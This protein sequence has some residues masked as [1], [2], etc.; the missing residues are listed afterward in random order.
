MQRST[1]LSTIIIAGLAAAVAGAQ[2]QPPPEPGRSFNPL[3]PAVAGIEKVRENLYFIRGQGG[4]TGVLV[5]AN[6]VVLVDTKLADN[7]QAILD[8]LR[9]VTDRPVT[10]IINTHTHPDHVGSNSF[11]PAS[12]E[13]VTHENTRANMVK[14]E[15][16]KGTPSALPDRTYKDRL[17]LGRGADQ[18]DLYYFGPGHTNGD[19]LVV[20]TA[21]RTMHSGDLFPFRALPLIDIS[22]GGSGVAYPATIER[23]VKGIRNVD[24]VI[25]GHMDTVQRWADFVEYGE[26]NREFLRAVENAHHAGRTAE[27]AAA[28]LKLPAKFNG[29][30]GPDQP[31]PALDFLWGGRGRIRGNVD[32]IYAELD[33]R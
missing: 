30:V 16:L 3:F 9:K 7:G 23:A 5:T 19:T 8:Q 6:G 22:S 32:V 33:G 10:T 28:E 27:Q 26:F 31:I 2:Q 13:V 1:V 15:E 25:T 21:A 18:I 17:T 14:M 29:Y 4:N 12:V 11:F 24:S 20:F